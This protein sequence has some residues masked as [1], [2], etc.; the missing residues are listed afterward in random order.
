MDCRC[1]LK[2]KEF[3]SEPCV[4][5]ENLFKQFNKPHCKCK[6][7][8]FENEELLN[9][10]LCGKLIVKC[11]WGVNSKEHNYCFWKW[12]STNIGGLNGNNISKLLNLSVQR[13]GQIAKKAVTFLKDTESLDQFKF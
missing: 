9:C 13:I 4:L 6:N 8:E 3:P 2:L 12:S 5:G 11:R 10:K 7:P 1:P